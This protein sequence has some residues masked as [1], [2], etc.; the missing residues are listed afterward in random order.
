MGIHM[1]FKSSNT[2]L[3]NYRV[4]KVLVTVCWFVRLFV[5]V[6]RHK[7]SPLDYEKVCYKAILFKQKVLRIALLKVCHNILSQEEEPISCLKS[8]FF[9]DLLKIINLYWISIKWWYLANI[10]SF[11]CKIHPS[12]FGWRKLDFI[13][14][15]LLGIKA[16]CPLNLEYCTPY[17]DKF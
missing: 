5:C 15:V 2:Y 14:N 7:V 3:Q 1:L 8:L 10:F 4:D 13:W 17:P 11:I 16:L 9:K 6:S 12:T